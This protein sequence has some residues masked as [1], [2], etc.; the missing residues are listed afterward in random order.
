M[1][2]QT[3]WL[4]YSLCA[5]AWVTIL[6]LAAVH[7]S[8]ILCLYSCIVVDYYRH[9]ETNVTSL[10][11]IVVT[12]S[13]RLTSLSDSSV[14]IVTVLSNDPLAKRDPSQLQDTEWTYSTYDIIKYHRAG[15]F[16]KNDIFKTNFT[17]FLFNNYVV[18]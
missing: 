17:L 13:A 11:L 9:A 4:L 5:S 12:I 2:G 8:I 7:Y 1:E 16:P 14:H 15:Y 18:Y 10:H 6:Q 3:E